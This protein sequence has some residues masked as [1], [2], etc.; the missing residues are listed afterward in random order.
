MRFLGVTFIFIKP[1]TRKNFIRKPVERYLHLL[2]F[3]L[4]HIYD[5]YFLPSLRN[6]MYVFLPVNSSSEIYVSLNIVQSLAN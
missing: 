3:S 1:P 2:T 4:M 6:L 5:H